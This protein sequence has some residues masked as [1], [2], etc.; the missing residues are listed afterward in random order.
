[1]I[2]ASNPVGRDIL[3]LFDGPYG[4]KGAP[5]RWHGTRLGNLE[6]DGAYLYPVPVTA[7]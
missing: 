6:I 1:L 7:S 5:R 2:G 3:T 4:P